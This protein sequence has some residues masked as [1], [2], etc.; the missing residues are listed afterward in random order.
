MPRPDQNQAT[1]TANTTAPT[2]AIKPAFLF[3]PPFTET[4]NGELFVAPAPVAFAVPLPAP[5][6]AV[7]V[8]AVA[9]AAWGVVG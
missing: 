9:P 5:Y 2:S 6:G 1:T 8:A 7:T 3:S 4:C